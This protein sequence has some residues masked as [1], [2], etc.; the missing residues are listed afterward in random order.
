MK[1]KYDIL[2]NDE[3]QHGER[4]E[5]RIQL[6]RRKL[7]RKNKRFASMTDIIKQMKSRKDITSEAAN[8]IEGCFGNIPAEMLKRTL[9]ES[10]KAE[11]SKTVRSFALTL[12]F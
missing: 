12:H 2:L 9:T 4:L 10:K 3:K 1:R 7:I 6:V 8:V 11:Y 5:T